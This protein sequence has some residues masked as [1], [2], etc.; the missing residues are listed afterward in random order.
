MVPLDGMVL[1][2]Q[3]LVN[4]APITGESWPVEKLPGSQVYAS[5][6]NG[7]GTFDFLVTATSEGT[8][9]AR[10][11][12]A[13]Q[14]AQAVRGPT[15]RYIDTFAGRYTPVILVLAAL[16]A[17]MPVAL[18]A[19]PLSESFYKALVIL[20]ISC[21]CALVLSTP[22]TIMSGLAAA[23]RQGILI[24]GGGTLEEGRKLRALA[25]D[26]GCSTTT[27]RLSLRSRQEDIT[28]KGT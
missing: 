15:Q 27:S 22:V 17:V 26:K 4:Q 9:L 5:T 7:S 16:T 14:R 21:P 18:W 19:Q 28:L 24:K 25:L 13:V 3:S 1:G 11:I 20:V 23:A 6:I 2:G 8:T 10:I 12:R